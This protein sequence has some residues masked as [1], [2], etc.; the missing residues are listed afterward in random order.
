MKKLYILWILCTAIL[1]VHAQTFEDIARF[2]RHTNFGT[3]RSAAMSGAFTAL[4]GDL[5][6]VSVNPAGIGVFRKSEINFSPL[7]NFNTTK[8]GY[9]DP[10]KTSF[11]VGN[12][13]AAISFYTPSLNWKSIN[14]SINYTNLNNF[15]R[16]TQQLVGVSSTSWT[17]AL[18]AEAGNTPSKELN[19]YTTRLAYETFLI[20]YNDLEEQYFSV[21][22][23]DE[24]VSQQKYITEKGNQGEYTLSFGT[25]YKDK[26]YLG[27]SVGIQ[28]IYYKME[29]NYLEG[30]EIEAP[31]FLDYYTFQE[32]YKING[33]GTNIKAG[34][35]Y[36]PIPELRIGAAIH[37]PTWYNLN[38]SISTTI[39]S[40]F[41]ALDEEQERYY[42]D[43]VA[44]S[45]DFTEPYMRDFDYDMKTPWRAVVGL[46]TVLGSK[47]IL[48]ADY[49]YIKYTSGQFDDA[50][51]G[52]SYQWENEDIKDFLRPTHNFR[53][54]AEYRVNSNFS[55][56]AGY[57]FWD[58]PYHE[59]VKKSNNRIQSFSAGAGLNFGSFYCDAAYVHKKMR[60]QTQF[61][62][63]EEII[64]EP[65][66]NKYYT[67]EARLSLGIRF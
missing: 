38:Q 2:G 50:S 14:F 48:S 5:S 30:A 42:L 11:Q 56:R 34:F 12:L 53:A 18:A 29:S 58:S 31:S 44:Y 23:N 49:E 57:A 59:A 35:I 7:L 33:V 24:Y 17:D 4:G 39:T 19:P 36:R 27:V 64:A 43:Y 51:D 9:G 28:S 8:S 67:H 65:V 66:T 40:A 3:A 62:G 47:A 20:N 22:T 1:S 37:S 10:N 15:N 54:G 46:A 6:A 21:L 13:G 32:S 61:Y 52:Y 16:K 25:N 63:Y 45:D 41:T 26:L 60:N 55:L